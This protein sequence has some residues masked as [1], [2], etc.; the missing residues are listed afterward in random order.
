MVVLS[1][2][3]LQGK[4]MATHTFQFQAGDELKSLVIYADRFN[5]HTYAYLVFL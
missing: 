1:M 5:I 4:N 3:E 2:Y